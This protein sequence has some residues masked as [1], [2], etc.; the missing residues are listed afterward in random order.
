[1]LNNKTLDWY[2]IVS[3]VFKKKGVLVPSKDK[4]RGRP[5]GF[6][7]YTAALCAKPLRGAC[8]SLLCQKTPHRS[9]V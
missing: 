6:K 9:A 3:C 7:V 5:L 1:M 2:Y 8:N 4:V